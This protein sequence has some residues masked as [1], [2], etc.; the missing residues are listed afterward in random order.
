MLE[1]L[2]VFARV[3][4]LASFTQAAQALDVPKASVSL[5][6]QRL[7]AELGARLLHRTTRRVQLTHD[8]AALYERAKDLLSDVDELRTLFRASGSGVTGRLR[9]DMPLGAARN[10]LVPR[11]P[12]LLAAH[13]GL[14]IE[15]S[16]TDR[17]VD[18]V[19]EGFDCVLRVGALTD[20]SL[21]ARPLGRYRLINCASPAYLAAHGRL[22]GEAD[23]ARH[24]LVHYSPLLGARPTGFEIEDRSASGGVRFVEMAGAVTVNNSEAYVA[25]CLAGLGIV[26]VPQPGV[27]ALLADGRLVEVLPR[28][29]APPMPVALLY[30]HRRQLP[31]RVQV[32]MAWVHE[33]MAPHLMPRDDAATHGV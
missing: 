10:L 31:R 25:A 12:E 17:R 4:E 26:Q 28:L 11:L 9:V 24:R 21:I 16:S 33:L 6:V 13:P 2:K 22:R 1:Q 27:A 3:A 30:P 5:A 18:V 19:R 8:G 29:R 15:L 14:A 23:L 20:S 7:E 32:F